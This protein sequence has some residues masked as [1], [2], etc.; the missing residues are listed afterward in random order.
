MKNDYR[1]KLDGKGVTIS[2]PP[3]LLVTAVAKVADSRLARTS[4]FKG[5]GDY[6]YVLGGTALGLVGSEL[7][8]MRGKTPL[9]VD[10]PRVG[11]PN[12]DVARKIYSWL[13]GAVGREQNRLRSVHDVSDGGILT[14]VAESL[15]ARNLGAVIE[16]DQE[17]WEFFFG[18]G[19]HSFVV[20]LAE[21]DASGVESEW[22]EHGVPFRRIGQ[23]KNSGKL[24]A[25]AAGSRGF[26]VETRVLRQAWKKEGYWE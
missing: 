16:T 9:P 7:H 23:V 11:E 15:L 24:E 5:S 3:T 6:I 8:S 14:A 22:K 4:D 26:V 20:S 1:G 10:S 21:G 18:E 19:F 12:W 13:G 2:V 17:P 25:R